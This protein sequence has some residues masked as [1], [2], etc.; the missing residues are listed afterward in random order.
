MAKE[1]DWV[2]YANL[3]SNLFQNLQLSGV[4]DKLGAMVSAAASEQAKTQHED[5][6]REV[7]FQADTNLKGLGAHLDDEKTGVLAVAIFTLANFELNEV[8][9]TSFRSYEDKE[10]LRS[11][12]EGFRALVKECESGLSADERAEAQLCAQYMEN[13]MVMAI[14][15]PELKA[16]LRKAQQE[17]SELTV[18]EKLASS[19]SLKAL[20]P[21]L[22]PFAVLAFG[23]PFLIYGEAYKPVPNQLDVVGAGI[24]SNIGL[25]LCLTG[26]IGLAVTIVA[27]GVVK[28][29][30]SVVSRK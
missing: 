20:A 13:P 12:L 15:P 28:V 11:V 24:A 30:A 9:S 27:K 23:L 26:A 19:T 7:V 29:V 25:F 3:G 5:R 21:L 10:R 4:Q 2:D 6:L 14:A 22:I 16:Q 8:T 18:A 17:L 1:R